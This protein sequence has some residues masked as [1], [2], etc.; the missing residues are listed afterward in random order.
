MLRSRVGRTANSTG[1]TVSYL[2]TARHFVSRL[3]AGA[4]A[5]KITDVEV[6]GRG[7]CYTLHYEKSPAQPPKYEKYSTQA[8]SPSHK[9]PG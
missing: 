9:M 7:E 5:A 8:N 4:R 1:L 6:F 3:A 2:D